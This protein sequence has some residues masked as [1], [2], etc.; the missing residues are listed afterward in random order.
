MSF[1]DER[2]DGLVGAWHLEGIVMGRALAQDVVVAWVLRGAYLQIHYLP[3]TVTPLTDHP[4]EAIAYVGW[5]PG[6]GGRFVMFLFDVFGAAYPTPGV[7]SLLDGGGVRFVF[8]YPQ[9]RF[10]TDLVPAERGWR[11]DQ[12]S[13]GDDGDLVAFGEKHL[14]ATS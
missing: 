9:G 11:I 5:D 6:E 7:G 2:L 10:V 3:S 1:P 4:Y 12:F 13:V 8:D 14:T